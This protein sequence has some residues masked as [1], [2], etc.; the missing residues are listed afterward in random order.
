MSRRIRQYI[1]LVAAVVLYYVI[2]EGAHLAVALALGVFKQIN[3]IGL[4][5][6]IDV[7]AEQMTS[8]QMGWFCAA[9]LIATFIAGWLLVLFAGKICSMRSALIRTCAWY[10]SLTMLIL[11]PLYLGVFYRWVGG[12]DMNGIA[13]IVPEEVATVVAAIIGVVNIIVIWKALYP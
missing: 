6:Q 11:D 7:F 3:I 8:S 10:T 2:H 12:G 4:G 1:G 13:L 5:M 9:G